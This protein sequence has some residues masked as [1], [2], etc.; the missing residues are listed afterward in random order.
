MY[1]KIIRPL[2]FRID[3]ERIH[4][5]INTGLK[6]ARCV[7]I[8]KVLDMCNNP[9]S[10]QMETEF[11][12]I[13][14]PNKIGIAAGFDKNAEVY[15][16]LGNMGFGHVEIGTVTPRPQP[17]NP[18]PR[19][20]RLPAD[21]ALINRMGFNNKGVENAVKNLRR[22]NHKI[23]IGG[24]IGKNSSTPNEKAVDDYVACFQ[25]LYDYVDYITV[26]VSCPNVTNLRELQGQESLE[27]IL[28][29][30]AEQRRQKA[31]YKP[32][33]LKISPDLNFQQIDESLEIIERYGIDGLVAA[34]T[35]TTR[36]GLKTSGERIKE[37]AN[38]GLSGQPL[39][40][41]SVEIISYINKKTGGKLPIIGVGGTMS[42]A[43][44][45]AKLE[46]GA[47][48]VQVFTGFI[49]YGP[50][51]AKDVNKAVKNGLQK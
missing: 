2:L 24:N 50:K 51:L 39:R 1:Q 18:K 11:C 22:R 30:L 9:R 37:I 21:S 49:Y 5:V 13:K 35:S 7:G 4:S 36:T 34:N 19:L 27:R 16:M 10:L 23:V 41:R 40:D 31:E 8:G 26:N 42:P 3:P 17:G 6:V 29:A 14:F 47:T 28:S 46:A 38:G 15:K 33:L 45:M 20:F 32:I 25:A 44:A 12:G 43:D 48:L